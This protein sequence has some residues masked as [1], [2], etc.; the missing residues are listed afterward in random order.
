M[1]AVARIAEEEK[2]KGDEN[3]IHEAVVF[4]L[5]HISRCNPDMY[6]E[7]VHPGTHKEEGITINE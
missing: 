5:G 3:N 1:L 4:M 6:Q 7:N 2:R